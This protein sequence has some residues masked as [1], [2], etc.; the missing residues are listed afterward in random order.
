MH[1]ELGKS[2]KAKSLNILGAQ[3]A[4]LKSSFSRAALCPIIIP[5][6]T[7]PM[8]SEGFLCIPGPTA[9]LFNIK[10]KGVYITYTVHGKS[11]VME[12]ND[13]V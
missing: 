4:V 5:S 11:S 9:T 2:G 12:M 3:A 8:D 10:K 13:T 6:G 1:S 7:L